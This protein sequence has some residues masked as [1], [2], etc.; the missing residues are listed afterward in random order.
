MYIHPFNG[1]FSSTTWVSRYQK[2]KNRSGFCRSNR[3]LVAVASAGPYARMQIAPDR[4][5]RQHSTTQ[6]FTGW[7]P[8]LPPSQQ[9]QSTEGRVTGTLTLLWTI[10]SLCHLSLKVLVSSGGRKQRTSWPTL[11]HKMEE[12][13]SQKCLIKKN[14]GCCAA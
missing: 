13:I 10:T 2:G 5:L 9:H 8:F 3:Q 6:S 4:Q 1:P 11:A 12:M 7:M 14:L